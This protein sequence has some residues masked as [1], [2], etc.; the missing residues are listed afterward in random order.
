MRKGNGLGPIR[1]GGMP[2]RQDRGHGIP[3]FWFGF[4]DD[5]R[6]P[7][8]IREGRHAREMRSLSRVGRSDVRRKRIRSIS[9]TRSARGK[10]GDQEEGDGD[11]PVIGCAGS[12]A[13]GRGKST[14]GRLSVLEHGGLERANRCSTVLF[15]PHAFPGGKVAAG[16]ERPRFSGAGKSGL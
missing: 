4:K 13:G 5:M 12:Q 16:S 15:L 2:G 6:R 1:R 9:T 3:T 14:P 11:R 10:A 8:R 7:G